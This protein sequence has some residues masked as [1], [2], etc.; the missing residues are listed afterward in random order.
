ME[1]KD[2][3]KIAIFGA[4][5]IGNSWA[6][7]FIWKGYPVNLWLYSADEETTAKKEIQINLIITLDIL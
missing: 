3:K 2:I 6:T 5:V 4:G 1:A 7:N